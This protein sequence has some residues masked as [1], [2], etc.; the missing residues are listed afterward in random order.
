M[1]PMSIS[2]L[3]RRELTDMYNDPWLLSLVTWVPPLLFL[4]MYWLFSQGI[5]TDLPIGVV[6]LDKSRMSRS[7][8]RHYDASPSLAVNSGYPSIDS[9][10]EALRSGK[11]YALAVL[12]KG[13]EE[14]TVRRW[15]PQV[16]AF[17]NSQ[18]L[19]IGN[20]VNI[21]LT[22]A[23]GTF[24]TKTEVVK[25]MATGT[26]VI[27]VALSSAVPMNKQIIPLFNVN[28]NY[29]QF[30]VSAILPALWQILIIAGTIIS[31]ALVKRRYGIGPWLGRSPVSRLATKIGVLT[32]VFWLHG[33]FFLT[34]MYVWLGWPMRGSWPLLLAGQALTVVVSVGVGCVFFLLSRDAARCLSLAAAYVAPGFAFMGVTFP[35]SDMTFPARLWR[36]L[37][38]ICHYIEIQFA[39]VNYGAAVSS[40]F[41]K[42]GHLSLF[43]LPL[44]FCFFLAN[45]QGEKWMEKRAEEHT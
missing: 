39:Q 7:L 17:V 28:K 1:P 40:A 27:G 3:L 19:L 38:P 2:R 36:S 6:D 37:I 13:L 11:I 31:M 8:T 18:F 24:V 21:A 10:A 26:P 32:V 29:A 12:P 33:I 5:A 4:V 22:Q 23:H 41:P 43:L 9:G 30:L 15:A 44:L 16:S 42:L 25:N 34:L 20:I 45:R 14:E 35:V